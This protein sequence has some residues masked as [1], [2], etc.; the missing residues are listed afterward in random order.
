MLNV[1]EGAWN[2]FNIDS[3]PLKIGGIFI[4]V[5]SCPNNFLKYFRLFALL[6]ATLSPKVTTPSGKRIKYKNLSSGQKKI[7]V[8]SLTHS[9]ADVELVLLL[10]NS[11]CGKRESCFH[12]FSRTSILHKQEIREWGDVFYTLGMIWSDYFN[13]KCNFVW[14]CMFGRMNPMQIMLVEMQ[15]FLGSNFVLLILW[16]QSIASDC[17]PCFQCECSLLKM[18]FINQNWC[19]SKLGWC[20]LANSVDL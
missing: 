12:S 7:A 4:F 8:N 3:F 11:H 10:P 16:N 1:W 20:C 2:L 15:S 19:I 9:S 5:R 17:L 18:L 14:I 6:I 13:V